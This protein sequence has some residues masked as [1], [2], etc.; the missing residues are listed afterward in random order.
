M[1]SSLTRKRSDRNKCQ[2]RIDSRSLSAVCD[3]TGREKQKRRKKKSWVSFGPDNFLQITFECLIV[4][5]AWIEFKAANDVLQRVLDAPESKSRCCARP[6]DG[7]E[8]ARL[9]LLL[10]FWSSQK[11]VLRR[12]RV[13]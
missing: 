9:E 5:I 8:F 12:L 3:T 7:C 10:C 1:F 2:Y 13:Q 11:F 4:L 6:V